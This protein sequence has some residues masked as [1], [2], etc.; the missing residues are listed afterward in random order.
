MA[1]QP[2][3]QSVG[4]PVGATCALRTENGASRPA[5]A[6]REAAQPLR[7][8]RMVVLL[9]G[10]PTIGRAPQ[11]DNVVGNRGRGVAAEHRRR[12]AC[13]A[14]RL[15]KTTGNGGA[16][17]GR[18]RSHGIG[19][20]SIHR[21]AA[22]GGRPAAARDLESGGRAIDFDLEAC[23]GENLR[24]A[25]TTPSSNPLGLSWGDSRMRARLRRARSLDPQ[26]GRQS[27]RGNYPLAD[28]TAWGVSPV[29]PRNA[30]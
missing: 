15:S 1:R 13:E 21:T 9:V 29:Q 26:R 14:A 18:R 4:G 8:T 11:G 2:G 10:S 12:V 24:N 6:A 23:F 17:V 3:P 27:C 30:L 28:R 19:G 22:D 16:Y 7:S 5:T 25:S 20:G